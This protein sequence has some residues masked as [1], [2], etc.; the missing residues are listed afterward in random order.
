[1]PSKLPKPCQDLV[2]AQQGQCGVS[3]F[4][5]YN[6]LTIPYLWQKVKA[7][8]CQKHV[9]CGYNDYLSKKYKRRFGIF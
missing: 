6:R 7:K 9:A 5:D 2:C 1:M 3:I 8:R 4:I